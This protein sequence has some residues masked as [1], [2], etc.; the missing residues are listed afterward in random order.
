MHLWSNMI[1]EPDVRAVPSKLFNTQTKRP[2][3][4]RRLYR[5]PS[6]ITAVPLRCLNAR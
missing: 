3:G 5:D 6:P 2:E 4:P 1:L